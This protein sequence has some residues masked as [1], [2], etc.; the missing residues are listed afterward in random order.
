METEWN[1]RYHNKKLHYNRGRLGSL[2][3]SLEY[4]H[5]NF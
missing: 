2:E 3:L 4:I 1:H 5:K